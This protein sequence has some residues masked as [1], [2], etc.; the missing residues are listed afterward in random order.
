[1]GQR[2]TAIAAYRRAAHIFA[3]LALAQASVPAHLADFAATQGMLVG[4]LEADSQPAEAERAYEVARTTLDQLLAATPGHPDH[5]MELGQL[6][7]NRSDQ[8]KKRG[9]LD[10]TAAAL[11]QAIAAFERVSTADPTRAAARLE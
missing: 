3:D 2:S 8:L 5:T 9:Q 4:P 11:E 6:F 1:L 7:N 10:A